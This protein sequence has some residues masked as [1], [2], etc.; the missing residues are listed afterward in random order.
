MK[1]Y[2]VKM[3]K[4]MFSPKSTEKLRQETEDEIN[5]G[6]AMGWKLFKVDFEFASQSGYIYSYIIFEK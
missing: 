3:V 4:V 2:E 6:A 5:K 1:S